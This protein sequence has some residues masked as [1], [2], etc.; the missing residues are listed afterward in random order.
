MH[1]FLSG[2]GLLLGS[3]LSPCLRVAVLPQQDAQWDV[4]FSG[5][6]THVWL[7]PEQG[8]S[9]SGLACHRHYGG[10]PADKAAHCR[11]AQKSRHAAGFDLSQQEEE[12]PS[13]RRPT[14]PNFHACHY[15]SAAA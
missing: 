11:S 1:F 8:S 4:P 15:Q 10:P 6:D 13:F 5:L 12:V 7:L 2:F 14:A 3:L 9:Q